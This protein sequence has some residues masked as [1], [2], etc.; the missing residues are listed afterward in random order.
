MGILLWFLLARRSY[1]KIFIPSTL[2]LEN[3]GLRS[4]EPKS[5]DP[6]WFK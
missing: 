1:T 4:I 6:E 5:C 2:R 3:R